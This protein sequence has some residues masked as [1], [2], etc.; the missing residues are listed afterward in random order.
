MAAL[1]C[2][3]NWCS[4]VIVLSLAQYIS[5]TISPCFWP[6]GTLAN[7]DV[8][9]SAGPDPT[10]CCHSTHTCLSNKLCLVPDVNSG[11][12]RYK[13]G[14]CTDPTWGS[15]ACT[16]FCNIGKLSRNSE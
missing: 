15:S 1:N 10:F 11:V 4:I 12:G 8:P 16:S 13:R 14:T 5:A 2:A 6:D 3:W 9:C 7:P